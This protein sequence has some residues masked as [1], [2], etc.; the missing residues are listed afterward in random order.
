MKLCV[1]IKNA[2]A[3]FQHVRREFALDEEHMRS[4]FHPVDENQRIAQ[5]FDADRDPREPSPAIVLMDDNASPRDEGREE[6]TQ[7]RVVDLPRLEDIEEEDVDTPSV[8]ANLDDVPFVDDVWNVKA[9]YVSVEPFAK[10]VANTNA[11]VI[12]KEFRDRVRLDAKTVIANDWRPSRRID[13]IRYT[14]K[15]RDSRPAEEGAGIDDSVSRSVVAGEPIKKRPF[16]AGEH[17]WDAARMCREIKIAPR[18]MNQTTEWICNHEDSLRGGPGRS[19][20]VGGAEHAAS[21]A[22]ALPR[23]R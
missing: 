5:Q 21:S 2:N 12:R 10:G 3:S 23:P 4:P 16:H 6:F 9:S 17:R 7:N 11:L 18:T 1:E 20:T 8:P 13:T 19:L 22:R 14:S 15:E